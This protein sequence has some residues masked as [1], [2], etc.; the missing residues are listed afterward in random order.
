MVLAYEEDAKAREHA[1][2][3]ARAAKSGAVLTIAAIVV[4]ALNLRPALAALG[5]VLD[6]V[7]AATGASSAAAGLLTTLPIFLM[8]LGALLAAPLRRMLGERMGV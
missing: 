6:T 3:A 8:G 7:K 4:A 1:L 5:P 2:L